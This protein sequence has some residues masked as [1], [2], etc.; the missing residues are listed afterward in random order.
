MGLE[1]DC[2]HGPSCPHYGRLTSLAS[3]FFN[4]YLPEFS[5]AQS[6]WGF[7]YLL[8]LYREPAERIDSKP[9]V[10]AFEVY[11]PPRALFDKHKAKLPKGED[12]S[13]LRED[14]K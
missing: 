9:V 6:H 3:I 10:Y 7:S 2:Q 8:G 5:R 14:M 11:G 4:P 1:N 13:W 12:S